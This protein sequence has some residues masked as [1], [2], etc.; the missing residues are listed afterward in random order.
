MGHIHKDIDLTVSI[1]IVNDGK[2]LLVLHKK[3]KNWLPVGGHVELHEDA[4]E[5]LRREIVEECGLEVELMNPSTPEVPGITDMKFLP[6]P[7]GFDIHGVGGGHRHMNLVY[8]GTSSNNKFTLDERE[9]NSI[10][11]FTIE[12]LDDPAWDIWPSIKFY[13]KQAINKATGT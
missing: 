9:H 4:E 11:W 6:V 8:F 5:A 2:V 1:Y 13:A 7:D 10:R 12:E 3:L